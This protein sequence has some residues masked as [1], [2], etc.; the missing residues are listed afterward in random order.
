MK[1]FGRLAYYGFVL[2]YITVCIGVI[3]KFAYN[4]LKGVKLWKR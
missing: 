4:K 2:F 3:F 1:D